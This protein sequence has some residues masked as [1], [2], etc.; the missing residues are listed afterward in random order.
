M[1]DKLTDITTPPSNPSDDF[2][3]ESG[4]GWL[5]FPNGVIMQ[6]GIWGASPI[7]E[8]R[9]LTWNKPY[10]IAPF[11]VWCTHL[12]TSSVCYWIHNSNINKTGVELG[13]LAIYPGR[14]DRFDPNVTDWPTFWF[15][16]GI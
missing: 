5:K 1:G 3:W 4:S 7:G 10:S 11:G 15:S 8:Y 2:G 6:C 16:I 13:C 9:W 12:G 14:I